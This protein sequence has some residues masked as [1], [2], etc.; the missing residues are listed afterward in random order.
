[1]KQIEKKVIVLNKYQMKYKKDFESGGF[2]VVKNKPMK[3]IEKI[4]KEF[5]KKFVGI[6]QGTKRVW[7]VDSPD[8]V[9]DWIIKTLQAQK[10]DIA[11]DLLISNHLGFC[12]QTV[13]VGTWYEKEDIKEMIKKVRQ[14]TREEAYIRGYSKGMTQGYVDGKLT[15]NK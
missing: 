14:D 3:Q 8:R 9:L 15:K 11:D 1:M 6:T 4:K 5:E 12:D 7:W 13:L 10:E 2:K